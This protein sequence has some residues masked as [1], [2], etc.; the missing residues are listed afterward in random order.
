M[1]LGGMLNHLARAED[2]WFAW[3]LRGLD[4]EPPW[5]DAD[6]DGDWHND[7]ETSPIRFGGFG[8]KR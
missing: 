6:W 4:P 5:D 3:F 2:S 8:V 1:T 7:A